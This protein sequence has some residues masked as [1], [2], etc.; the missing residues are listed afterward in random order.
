LYQYQHPG[1]YMACSDGLRTKVW[2]LSVNQ[3][4]KIIAEPLHYK[5]KKS[6]SKRKGDGN[7]FIYWS[8]P[9]LPVLPRALPCSHASRACSNV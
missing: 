1:K 4:K 2:K 5:L 8:I 3:E 6:G 7:N 9:V